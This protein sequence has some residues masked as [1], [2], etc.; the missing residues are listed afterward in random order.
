M[1]STSSRTVLSLPLTCLCRYAET[2]LH[3]ALALKILTSLELLLLPH[4]LRSKPNLDAT[5]R[6][7]DMN[8]ELLP[9]VR[10]S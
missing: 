7:R 5:H 8:V 9:A 2:D 4:R 10:V 6:K 1:G 3:F